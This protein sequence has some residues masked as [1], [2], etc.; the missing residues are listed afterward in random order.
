MAKFYNF[1][2]Y[3][4]ERNKTRGVTFQLFDETH[5]LPPTIPFDA[6]LL[7]QTMAG[8]D[9][10]EKVEDS[11]IT[12]LF[13]KF[14]GKPI[15][16]SVVSNPMFDIDLMTALMSW[17]L[18]QYGLQNETPSPKDPQEAAQTPE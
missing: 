4:Q 5:Y 7:L 17:I 14:V 2:E 1:D 9:K 6:A 10:A 15:Y 11:F 13:I 3:V 12:D 18:K 16:D 8:R